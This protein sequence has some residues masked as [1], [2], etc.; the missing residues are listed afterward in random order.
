NSQR[1]KLWK[2]EISMNVAGRGNADFNEASVARKSSSSIRCVAIT[3][4]RRYH[5]SLLSHRR[6]FRTPPSQSDEFTLGARRL[7]ARLITA[8][9]KESD[10]SFLRRNAF[11]RSLAVIRSAAEPFASNPQ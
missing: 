8:M 11:G 6:N 10:C 4:R 3:T 7:R 9:Q 1:H 5:K 2:P